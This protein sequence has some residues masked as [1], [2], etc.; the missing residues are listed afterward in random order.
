MGGSL[1]TGITAVIFDIDD[2]LLDY[3]AAAI[4]GAKRFWHTFQ[5][6]LGGTEESF[7]ELWLKLTEQYHAEYAHG[8]ISFA[9]QR[10]ERVRAAFQRPFADS[11]ADE[12]FTHY[13]DCYQQSWT[14]FDD[15]LPCL[16][17]LQPHYPLAILTNGHIDHQRLKIER[18]DLQDRFVAFVTPEVAGVPKPHPRIFEVAC[19]L[20]QQQPKSCLYVGDKLEVDAL[21]AEAAGL[22][23]V[24]L[25][26]HN[27]QAHTHIHTITSLNQLG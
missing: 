5:T 10:R 7:V 21:A 27:T 15:V 4:Q 25:S 17:R 13:L 18:F 23:A 19:E 8:R 1:L 12:I 2:T 26:R 3:Y 22:R 9:E 14:L 24:W 6:E 11:A 16:N 20:L